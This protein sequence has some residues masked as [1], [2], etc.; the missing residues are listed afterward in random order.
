M[1]KNVTISFIGPEEMKSWLDAQAQAE[2]RSVSS[3]MRLIVESYRDAAGDG[4]RAQPVP[5]EQLPL[6]EAA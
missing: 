4:P 2:D 1:S 5:K 3:L 6:P